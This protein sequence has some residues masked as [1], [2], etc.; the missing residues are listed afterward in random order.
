M[1][2]CFF[3]IAVTQSPIDPR[4]T[5]ICGAFATS[6]PSASKIA[7]EKSSRS[8]MFTEE[9]V[10]RNVAPISSAMAMK[11]LANTSSETGSAS[12]V[13]LIA[14]FAAAARVSTSE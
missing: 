7:Q 13:A 2:L 8:L 4:C 11:R 1:A 5:G 3:M 14:A 6:P 12:V 10:F 9:A